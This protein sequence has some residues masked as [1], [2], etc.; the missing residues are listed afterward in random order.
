MR[1]Y[2][3]FSCFLVLVVSIG[4][5]QTLYTFS[6]T[7]STSIAAGGSATLNVTVSGVPTTGMVLR[8]V[9]I[10]FGNTATMNSGNVA[11]ITMRLKDALGN[12]STML[13]PTSFDGA[14]AIL[15]CLI[16]I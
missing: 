15:D 4:Q 7:T 3:I 16:Y 9:N 6:N 13:S 1:F 8:Q 14:V 2:K 12:I 5:S 11:S 10:G